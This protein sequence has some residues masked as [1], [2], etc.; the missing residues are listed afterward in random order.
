MR[1]TKTDIVILVRVYRRNLVTLKTLVILLLVDV[2]CVSFVYVFHL[3]LFPRVLFLFV[4]TGLFLVNK[5]NIQ[6]KS[7]QR[8]KSLNGAI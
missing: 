3:I 1:T 4:A 6:Y 5:K 7:T 8:F 2:L